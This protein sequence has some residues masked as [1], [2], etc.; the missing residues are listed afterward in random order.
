MSFYVSW[1]SF[2]DSM[3]RVSAWK[4]IISN[5]Q[6]R[7]ASWKARTLSRAGR[8]TLIKSVLNSL[9]IYYMSIFK[10]PKAVALSLVRLQRSFFWGAASDGRLPVPPIAWRSIE[11]P[12]SLGG[13]G[14]GNILY[15]NLILLFKWWWR[16]SDADN[17]L[18]KRILLSVHNIRGLKASSV[19]FSGVR[20]GV[21]GQLVSDE[22]DTAK[23]RR[24][25]ED[26]MIIRLGSGVSTLFWYDRWCECGILKQ[27]FPRL[28]ELSLQQENLVAQMGMWYDGG[29][30]WDFQWR[31]D[32]YSWEIEEVHRLERSLGSVH[33]EGQDSVSWQNISSL[34]YPTKCIVE[35]VFADCDPL[36]PRAVASILWSIRCPPRAQ[37]TLWM[38]CL[39][40]LKTGD[41]L[42]DVGV[43]SI[44]D[45]LCPL[46]GVVVESNSHVLFTCSFSWGVW[47]HILDWWGLQGVLQDR[48]GCA[49]LAWGGLMRSRRWKR[50]WWMVFVCVL[51]SIW[52]ER[53]AVKFEGKVADVRRFLFSLRLRVGFWAKE[54]RLYD[55]VS[56]GDFAWAP[57][58]LGS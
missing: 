18:W 14:V 22:V 20:E 9:P 8:L 4:P 44:S 10:I 51:W 16:F 37:V 27:L 41:R 23:V 43:I 32:L 57:G 6:D 2:I 24:I 45:A 39:G 48:C 33:R 30:V 26:G 3:T 36:L 7:L 35:Q 29:W 25:V 53:N 58:L 19:S 49:L 17:T 42:M 21:W 56:A 12:L 28:F 38:A 54:L 34:S 52:F 11:L 13:L 50:L 15:K 40:R 31:R 5:V 1:D 46:C 47:M 55:G